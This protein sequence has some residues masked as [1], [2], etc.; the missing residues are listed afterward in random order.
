MRE[1]PQT[2]DDSIFANQLLD[3]FNRYVCVLYAQLVLEVQEES[4]LATGIISRRKHS[5]PAINDL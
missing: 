4:I 2:F 1:V 3:L 5:L